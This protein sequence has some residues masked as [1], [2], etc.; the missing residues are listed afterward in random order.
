MSECAVLRLFG[1]KNGEVGEEFPINWRPSVARKQGG[2][3]GR[4]E[5]EG[6]VG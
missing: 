6:L 4:R 1:L 3:R 2:W 5:A